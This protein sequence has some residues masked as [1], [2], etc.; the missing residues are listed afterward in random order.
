MVERSL[1]E[2]VMAAIAWG[3]IVTHQLRVGGTASSG[4]CARGVG[5]AAPLR[6]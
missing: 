2:E 6:V 3:E 1:L 5:V 4:G